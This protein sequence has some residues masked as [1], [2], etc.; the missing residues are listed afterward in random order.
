M[1]NFMRRGCILLAI[2]VGLVGCG[3]HQQQLADRG[4]QFEAGES[5]YVVVAKIHP[6]NCKLLMTIAGV[7]T[8]TATI[9]GCT[10]EKR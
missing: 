10:V 7:K 1:Y 8:L 3:N 9:D 4:K 6:H 5:V 2:C